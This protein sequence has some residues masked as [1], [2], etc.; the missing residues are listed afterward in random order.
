M[1]PFSGYKAE[2]EQERLGRRIGPVRLMVGAAPYSGT[3]GSNC[4]EAI[5]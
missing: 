4:R 3:G 1:L 5:S 2:K